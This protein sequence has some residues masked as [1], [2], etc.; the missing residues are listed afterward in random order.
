MSLSRPGCCFLIFDVV[1]LYG[2]GVAGVE[3][4]EQLQPRDASVSAIFF[5]RGPFPAAGE[6]VDV[7]VEVLAF[8]VFVCPDDGWW[9][10]DVVVGLEVS[11]VVADFKLGFGPVFGVEPSDDGLD[12]ASFS[13]FFFFRDGYIGNHLVDSLNEPCVI[14]VS[15][16]EP[17]A[18]SDEACA[19]DRFD[20][21]VCEGV[22]VVVASFVGSGA[23]ALLNV[24]LLGVPFDLS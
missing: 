10:F 3:E 19:V 13:P 22:A 14:V 7:S 21:Y 23:S 5:N 20:A 8:V 18:E 15:V 4:D 9:Y 11:P 2:P 17:L 16:C 6:V 12:F 1:A 24:D